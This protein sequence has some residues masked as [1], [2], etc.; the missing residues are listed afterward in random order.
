MI[1]AILPAYNEAENLASLIE[2]FIALKREDLRIIVVD[3]GST[4]ATA[5]ITREFAKKISIELVRHFRNQ[6]LD[7]ALRS[8]INVAVVCGKPG[9]L[10]CTM[11]ADNS[12]PPEILPQM[13]R[14]I[15][16]SDCVIA[17]RYVAQ[18]QV[19]GVPLFRRVG[20]WAAGKI[21]ERLFAL[22]GVK[23]YTCGFRLLRWEL[24]HR[25]QKETRGELFKAKGFAATCELLLVLQRYGA[26]FCETPLPLRY[27]QK[28]G[29]SKMQIIPTLQAYA[30]VLQRR[31]EWH[32]KN[33]DSFLH[34]IYTKFK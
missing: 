1:F 3:D 23:D 13:E 10:I 28:K 6:G 34:K 19:R 31:A 20:S 27:D 21:F 5:Q 15:E 30:D 22:E 17:S 18:A 32:R 24:L 7:A 4:D 33:S 12:H 16:Q 26:R 9:D 29:K 14:A 11:D 2:R 8:G 25:L